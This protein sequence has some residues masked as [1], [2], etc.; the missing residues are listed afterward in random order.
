MSFY[1][2]YGNFPAKFEH[3]RVKFNLPFFSLL[4]VTCSTHV[5]TAVWRWRIKK[6]ETEVN[7]S[8]KFVDIC[9]PRAE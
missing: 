5:C 3:A 9:F 1:V 6:K 2:C 4:A 8:K 7:G